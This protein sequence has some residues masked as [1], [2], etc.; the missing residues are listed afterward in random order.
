MQE[1]GALTL[2]RTKC[3]SKQGKK[4]LQVN[5]ISKRASWEFDNNSSFSLTSSQQVKVGA[6]GCQWILMQGHLLLSISGKDF[7]Y[8][9]TKDRGPNDHLLWER[10]SHRFQLRVC[11]CDWDMQRCA[12]LND[13]HLPV[14]VKLLTTQSK[15]CRSTGKAEWRCCTS[16]QYELK[17]C[18]L[19]VLNYGTA[20][21]VYP[22]NTVILLL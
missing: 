14:Q 17:I 9:G 18:A 21:P 19:V 20:S 8:L 11:P 2:W 10:Q 3:I 7:S 12:C 22:V 13:N 16:C 1:A 5:F 6:S 15:V 4:K